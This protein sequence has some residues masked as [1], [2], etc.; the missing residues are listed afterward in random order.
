MR[1]WV[2]GG[3]YVGVR[4]DDQAGAAAEVVA[5]GLLLA[6]RL[7]VHVDDDGSRSQFAERTGGELAVGGGER[8]VE[9][10]HVDAAHDVGH[11]HV[12]AVAGHG[13]RGAA[14]GRAAGQVVGRPEQARLAFL[15]NTSASRWSQAW[16]PVVTTSAPASRKL[17]QMSSVMPVAAAFSP[18]TTTKSSR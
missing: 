2:V 13:H 5:H 18:L 15:M 7:G 3:R 9:R 6:G 4:A 11:Q 1:I 12:G 17:W 8:I 10:V 16:L 14:T